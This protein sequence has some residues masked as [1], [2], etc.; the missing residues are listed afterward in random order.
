LPRRPAMGK[1]LTLDSP[2]EWRKKG[3][4]VTEGARI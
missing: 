2:S 4:Q 1:T 3:S